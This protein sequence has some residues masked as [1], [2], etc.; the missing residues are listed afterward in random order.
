MTLE[1]L[2]SV[3]GEILTPAQVAPI[4][5]MDPNTLRAQAHEDP[6]ALGFGVIVT[7]CRVK[8]PKRAFIRFMLGEG[9]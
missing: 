9:K 7:G 3:P 1:E 8:I 2:Q 5:G 4:I 6:K